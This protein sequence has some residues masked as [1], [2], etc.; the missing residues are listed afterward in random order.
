MTPGQGHEPCVNAAMEVSGVKQGVLTLDLAE[1][2]PF[3]LRPRVAQRLGAEQVA[4]VGHDVPHL[5]RAPMVGEVVAV[6]HEA[7]HGGFRS[8]EPEEGAAVLDESRATSKGSRGEILQS[9]SD[10]SEREPTPLRARAAAEQ[11]GFD[12]QVGVIGNG[13][14]IRCQRDL[15]EGKQ[16]PLGL[17]H[18]HLSSNSRP[19]RLN[20]RMAAL[21]GD[22]PRATREPR[23]K[24][25]RAVQDHPWQLVRLV[26]I[27]D[28]SQPTLRSAC[29]VEHAVEEHLRNPLDRQSK[30]TR[31]NQREGDVGQFATI[32]LVEYTVEATA[33][34]VEVGR[35]GALVTELPRLRIMKAGMEHQPALRA[36]SD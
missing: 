27:E 9:I 8:A 29:E 21:T 34:G 2:T 3:D 30:D 35:G 28:D 4:D 15:R 19:H 20:D 7:L 1:P 33:N 23:R 36:R 31:S 24:C 22:Q 10:K 11:E 14:Q 12:G 13:R 25:T 32:G 17:L 18:F 6:H 5:A 26:H 16:Q